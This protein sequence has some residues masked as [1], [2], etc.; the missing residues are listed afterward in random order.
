MSTRRLERVEELL[1]RQLGEIIQREI[2]LTDIGLITVSDV[3]AAGDLRQA[4]VY[5]SILGSP[6]QKKKAIAILE[7]YRAR[8]QELLAKR[9]VLRYTPRIRFVADDS[10]ERADRV[11]RIIQELEGPDKAKR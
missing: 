6:E 10:I 4:T 9:I 11:L 3:E 5:V 8:I 1:K 7:K 2:H